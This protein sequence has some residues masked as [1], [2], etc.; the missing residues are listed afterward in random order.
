MVPV[1]GG[2]NH[3]DLGRAGQPAAVGHAGRDDVRAERQIALAEAAAS[4]DGP[5]Q[6]R[7]P[8]Q[9]RRQAPSWSSVAVPAKVTG[10]PCTAL[11]PLRRRR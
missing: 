4:A 7:R 1:G 9:R 11:V 2:D 10:T 5:L 8:Y 3:G 6:A